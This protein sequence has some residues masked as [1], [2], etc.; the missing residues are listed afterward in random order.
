MRKTRG[1]EG[2]TQPLLPKERTYKI[3]AG[4]TLV[5]VIVALVILAATV[6]GIFASFIASQRYV[7]TAKRRIVAVNFAR[8]KLEEL[9]PYVRQDTWTNSTNPLYSPDETSATPRILPG[10]FGTQWGGKRYYTVNTSGTYRP[11][12]VTVT[13]SEPQ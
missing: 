8:Q 1:A 5:E 2:F 4:F 13:W 9:R 3:R 7:A 6:A 10:D 11:V 12:N